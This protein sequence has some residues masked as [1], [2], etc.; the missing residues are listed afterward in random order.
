MMKG[1]VSYASQNGKE[2][3]LSS[4]LKSTVGQKEIRDMYH[5][6]PEEAWHALEMGGTWRWD[7]RHDFWGEFQSKVYYQDGDT[8]HW[9]MMHRE[10]VIE[11]GNLVVETFQDYECGDSEG[12]DVYPLLQNPGDVETYI[13]ARYEKLAAERYLAYMKWV[14]EN[15]S[16]PIGEFFLKPDDLVEKA[17]DSIPEA[18]ETLEFWTAAYNQVV[19]KYEEVENGD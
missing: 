14:A 8:W 11:G 19:A 17:I 3:E 18:T 13:Q 15:D 4:P 6:F 9:W 12:D 7:E 2:A 10:Y 5:W 1:C 16:D